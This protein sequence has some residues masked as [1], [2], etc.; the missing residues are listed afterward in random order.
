MSFNLHHFC[1]IQQFCAVYCTKG[2]NHTDD[3]EILKSHKNS[4]TKFHALGALYK[5]FLYKYSRAINQAVKGTKS[6][7]H[8]LKQ[9]HEGSNA[10]LLTY[11]LFVRTFF[12]AAG[13]L[14]ES[15]V[16]VLKA[17]RNTPECL[18][19]SRGEQLWPLAL[20]SKS[21][22]QMNTH[23]HAHHLGV[24]FSHARGYSCPQDSL[25][26]AAVFTNSPQPSL[27]LHI[28]QYPCICIWNWVEGG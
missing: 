7:Q 21:I 22:Q 26:E 19:M 5:R 18:W 4:W 16:S 8:P 24:T 12:C 9:S 6:A 15:W 14:G 27:C 20:S 25:R 13:L 23:T 28:D 11:S 17:S 3:A 2:K 10:V 1:Y